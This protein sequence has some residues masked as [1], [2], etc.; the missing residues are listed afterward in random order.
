MLNFGEA[1]ISSCA[2]S[3]LNGAEWATDG[4]SDCNNIL[5]CEHAVVRWIVGGH[6]PRW[7]M[8]LD[9]RRV[10]SGRSKAPEGIRFDDVTAG[11]GGI[12]RNH[13]ACG[14]NDV[15]I[16]E[17]RKFHWRT[18][19]VH[20]DIE[21]EMAGVRIYA[22]GKIEVTTQAFEHSAGLSGE[23]TVRSY[24]VGEIHAE[25][26]RRIAAASQQPRRK[27]VEQH[28]LEAEARKRFADDDFV[29][30]A[31]E[32]GKQ[33]GRIAAEDELRDQECVDRLTQVVLS[34]APHKVLMDAFEAF[35]QETFGEEGG[36]DSLLD[37]LSK[38]RIAEMASYAQIAY[39]R[40][41]AIRMLENEVEEGRAEDVLQRIVADA[42]WLI[43]ATRT[44]NTANQSLKLFARQFAAYYSELHSEE[45][46]NSI[47][48]GGKRPDSTLVN[49][50][51]KLH[52]IEIKAVGHRFANADWV[53]L[54][55]YLEAFRDFF[56]ENCDIVPD[57]RDGWV[58]D[59]V[60]DDVGITD[61]DN[62]LAY[63]YWR[64]TES[65]I[66]RVSWNDF[67]SRAVQANE[68]F[69][70]AEERRLESNPYS[71]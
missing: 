65:R 47:E 67:L 20:E 31:L 10:V 5:C 14:G 69:L 66:E 37:L 13:G 22:R 61:R 48:H 2:E 49:L 44:P 41:R 34:V 6:L 39:E 12:R 8:L 1:G 27:R 43:D 30:T 71:S 46:D 42:P 64:D 28:I 11:L 23:F 63:R 32:L 45:V 19:P 70:D 40:V 35:N 68:T 53:R 51:R 62:N 38:T 55:N 57:F 24:H 36:I 50:S 56:D 7:G 16:F 29:S 3:Q 9:L 4:F 25:W 33:I 52:M 59:L 18:R 26:I 15:N 54:H 21:R 60:C 58:V 17:S